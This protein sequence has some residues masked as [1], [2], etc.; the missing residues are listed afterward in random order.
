MGCLFLGGSGGAGAVSGSR[1]FVTAFLR[2]A[3]VRHLAR[4]QMENSGLGAVERLAL[5]FIAAW[6]T[7][8]GTL[9]RACADADPILGGSASGGAEALTSRRR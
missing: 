6:H 7:T 8:F 2:S 4:F 5:Q 9:F 3:L 1:Y